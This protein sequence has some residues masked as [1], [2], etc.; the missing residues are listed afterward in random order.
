MLVGIHTS[1]GCSR[2]GRRRRLNHRHDDTMRGAGRRDRRRRGHNPGRR[3]APSRRRSHHNCL[4][5]LDQRG[6]RGPCNMR[7]GRDGRDH[8]HLRLRLQARG[9]LRCGGGMH[10]RRRWRG[11]RRRLRDGLCAHVRHGR[12]DRWDS[13]VWWSR[14][15]RGC[16]RGRGWRRLRG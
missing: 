6:R 5:R 7:R 12:V 16:S 14:W 4:M 13:D 8:L 10:L 2:L 15:C 3:R 11:R 9:R 1:S